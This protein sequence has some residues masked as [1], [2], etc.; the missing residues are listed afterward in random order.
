MIFFTIRYSRIANNA[1]MNEA[2][3]KLEK[4]FVL[5]HDPIP[6]GLMEKAIA[7]ENVGPRLNLRLRYV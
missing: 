1:D 5:G 2:G 3:T 6:V 4:Y 7:T